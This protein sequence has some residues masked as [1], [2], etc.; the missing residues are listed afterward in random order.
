ML[1]VLKK[2]GD[3]WD[4]E[5]STSCH[6]ARSRKGP[7]A[8]AGAARG[9]AGSALRT[10]IRRARGSGGCLLDLRPL[11][12]GQ[13]IVSRPVGVGGLRSDPTCGCALAAARWQNC[14]RFTS[15]VQPPLVNGH[16]FREQGLR[17]T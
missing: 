4:E 14:G 7:S 10:A 3:G 15:Q 5:S 8:L 16:H 17:R 11:T 12:A 2:S 6:M 1:S 13:P 9:F